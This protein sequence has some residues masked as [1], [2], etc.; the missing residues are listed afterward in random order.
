MSVGSLEGAEVG[1]TNAIVTKKIYKH[2][3]LVYHGIDNE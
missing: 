1:I 3:S 2:V